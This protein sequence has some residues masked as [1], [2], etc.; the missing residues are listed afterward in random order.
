MVSYCYVLVITKLLEF[1]AHS[2]FS[3]SLI[4][5]LESGI[6]S[7]HRSPLTAE[8]ALSALRTPRISYERERERVNYAN[9]R[10]HHDAREQE[11]TIND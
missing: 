9:E 4:C 11:H 7:A 2:V 10:Q 6:L 8:L 3:L 1:M 5:T